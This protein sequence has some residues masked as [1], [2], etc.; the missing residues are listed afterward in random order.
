MDLKVLSKVEREEVK[1]QIEYY[2]EHRKTLQFGRFSRVTSTKSNKVFWQVAERDDSKVISGLFQT[3][4][5]AS[6]GFDRLK[7]LGLDP[8]AQYTVETKP[9]NLYVERFGEL[10]K[11]ILPIPLNPDGAILRFANRV[12][13]LHDGTEKYEGQGRVFESGLLLNNQYMG[14]G[15]NKQIRV[16]GDFGSSLYLTQK[17][18]TKKPTSD[19]VNDQSINSHNQLG[20]DV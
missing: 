4:A 17:S 15:Y 11:H 7:I 14:T 19:H 6:E 3:M 13:C 16:L 8:S 10:V 2:K 9:Q 5:I 18:E 1:A 12:Y 20:G